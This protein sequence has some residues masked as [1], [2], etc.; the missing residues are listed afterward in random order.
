[1]DLG[2]PISGRRLHLMRV[3]H[4]EFWKL[5]R[6]SRYTRE[7]L[8]VSTQRSILRMNL[9]DTPNALTIAAPV[10]ASP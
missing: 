10:I 5:V 8:T 1:M 9:L 3:T 2:E 7:E 4:V 6:L